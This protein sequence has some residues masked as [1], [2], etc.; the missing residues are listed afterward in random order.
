MDFVVEHHHM[1]HTLG[2]LVLYINKQNIRVFK[3]HRCTQNILCMLEV[4]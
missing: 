3:R 2:H 4:I 1:K